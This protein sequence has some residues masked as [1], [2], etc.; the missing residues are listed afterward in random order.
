MKIVQI[1]GIRGLIT[2]GFIG[3]CL[4]AGF[5]GFPGIVAMHLWNKYLVNLYMFPTLNL[6]QGI[7]LWG[8]CAISYCII[9]KNKFAVSFKNTP[10]LS[11]EE[12][13]SIIK[14]AKINSHM[15]MMNKII[16][17]SDKFS[18]SE[19]KKGTIGEN[20]KFVSSPLPQSTQT[21]SQTEAKET[22]KDNI[23]NIK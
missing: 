22:E 20:E 5:V 9:T 6:L 2:A 23:S 12:L 17:K 16:A 19:Q 1:D 14:N 13:N 15:Q 8:I 10:E 3:V 18:M 11:D 21:S 7:L 4:F